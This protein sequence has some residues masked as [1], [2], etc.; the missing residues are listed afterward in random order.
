MLTVPAPNT[1][2]HLARIFLN[3]L[4]GG[5]C[6]YFVITTASLFSHQTLED[7]SL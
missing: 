1:Y 5:S 3:G 4:G 7:S 6:F 2:S